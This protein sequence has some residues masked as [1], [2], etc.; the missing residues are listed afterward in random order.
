[1][2]VTWIAVALWLI[3]LAGTL[4]AAGF[5]ATI[6]VFVGVLAT[7]GAPVLEDLADPRWEAATELLDVVADRPDAVAAA[8]ELRTA[9]HTAILREGEAH[10]ALRAH[11]RIGDDGSAKAL[12]AK[13][14]AR[15]RRVLDAVRALHLA[16]ADLALPIVDDALHRLAAEREVQ[17]AVDGDRARVGARVTRSRTVR[18]G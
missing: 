17:S 12:V 5:T 3:A 1:M 10:A 16:H 13:E 4:F 18:S 9:L 2:D 8:T 14:E 11:A 15:I 6:L 7:T